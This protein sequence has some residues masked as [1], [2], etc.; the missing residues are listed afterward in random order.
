M[1]KEIKLKKY[2]IIL[3]AL[4]EILCMFLMYKSLSD[5]ETIIDNVALNK[6]SI[7]NKDMFAL[8]LQQDNGEYA[9]SS[10]NNMAN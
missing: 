4:L 1:E 8:M 6:E 10:E 2:L 3:L 9:E 7:I 5:K